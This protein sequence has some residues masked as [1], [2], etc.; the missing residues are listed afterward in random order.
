MSNNSSG[1]I[2]GD[3]CMRLGSRSFDS[4]YVSV[5]V[6]RVYCIRVILTIHQKRCCKKKGTAGFSLFLK[7]VKNAE[8][9]LL[10]AMYQ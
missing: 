3:I 10:S 6:S 4:L 5:M 1:V 9:C 8:L 7:A 2:D